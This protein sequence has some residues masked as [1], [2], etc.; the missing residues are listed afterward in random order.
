MCALQ[1][2]GIFK[3]LSVS[4]RTA[5]KDVYDLDFITDEIPLLELY[6]S[7]MKK[8]EKYNTES[9]KNIFDI[10]NT[11]PIANPDLLLSFDEKL[12]SSKNRPSHSDDRIVVL[13]GNKTWF[14]ARTSWKSKVRDLIRN[15]Q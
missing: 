7:L 8:Q 15:L 12:Q 3:L 1:D 9:D 2:I 5:N 11:N 6:Q 13:E 14:A 4:N 10:D